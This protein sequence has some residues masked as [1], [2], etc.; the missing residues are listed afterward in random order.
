MKREVKTWRNAS[1]SLPQAVRASSTM[2]RPCSRVSATASRLNSA[3]YVL[4]DPMGTPSWS[5]LGSRLGVHRTGA[6]SVRRR[7]AIL[8]FITD[9]K[10]SR[11]PHPSRPPLNTISV[12]CE[13]APN[14]LTTSF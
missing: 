7:A 2:V 6:R 8:T 12:L 9:M 4:R 5:T 11:A 1:L 13:R 14:R 10:F 3:L